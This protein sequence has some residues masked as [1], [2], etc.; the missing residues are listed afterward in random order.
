MY[1]KDIKESDDLE[2]LE[3]FLDRFPSGIYADL[4]RRRVK[5]LNS[6]ALAEDS[7]TNSLTSITVVVPEAEAESA[8]LWANKDFV[9]IAATT[10][11]DAAGAN[12]VAGANLLDPAQSAEVALPM[13]SV[14]P[15]R[16]AVAKTAAPA[17]DQAGAPAVV[18]RL[19]EQPGAIAPRE[20]PAPVGSPA[21]R[22]PMPVVAMTSMAVRV[23]SAIAFKLWSGAAAPAPVASSALTS[24]VPAITPAPLLAAP[25]AALL[26]ASRLP[27]RQIVDT[28]A[29]KLS[30]AKPATTK[31]VA[32]VNTATERPLVLASGSTP[33]QA[34]NHRILLGFQICMNEQCGK[35]AF[36][37]H[38]V[39]GAPC[40]GQVAPGSAGVPQL[41]ECLGLGVLSSKALFASF[42]YGWFQAQAKA[43]IDQ[44]CRSGVRRRNLAQ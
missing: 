25:L 20:L 28:A 23:A 15:D 10:P 12:A 11:A 35:A 38:P 26:P 18:A 33:M 41:K 37:N 34:C 30:A 31:P 6:L 24:G 42:R 2:D 21:R 43:Q 9:P 44:D 19:T 39:C 16:I 1:W 5:K 40:D 32:T 3:G 27:P 17:P 8:R 13:A 22:S 29:E 14:A 4:A 36:S 7:G